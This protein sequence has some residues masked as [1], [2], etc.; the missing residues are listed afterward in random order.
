[1]LTCVATHCLYGPNYAS[2]LLEALGGWNVPFG[3]LPMS[4]LQSLSMVLTSFDV[5]CRNFH[6]SRQH[7]I[8]DM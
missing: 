3:V 8:P 4:P 5:S 6:K 7:R 1:M 2:P